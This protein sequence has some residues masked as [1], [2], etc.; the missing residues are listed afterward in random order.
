MLTSKNSYSDKDNRYQSCSYSD[1]DN[2]YQLI[3]SRE[4]IAI[5]I[6]VSRESIAI[7]LMLIIIK[8]TSAKV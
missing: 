1:K 3:V 5:L 6:I 2:R 8:A 7:L 4:S